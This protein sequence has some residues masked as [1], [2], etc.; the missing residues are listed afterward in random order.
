MMRLLNLRKGSLWNVDDRLASRAYAIKV[1]NIWS[2]LFVLGSAIG[3]IIAVCQSVCL[4]VCH[5][6]YC[7]AHGRCRGWKLYSP[8][9]TALHTS[10]Y[11]FAVGCS[12]RSATT[13]SEN[14]IA[15]ISASVTIVTWPWLFQTRNFRR[16]G[17]AVIPYVVR[18][19]DRLS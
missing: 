10:S 3:M 7:G 11:T 6:V 12:Y 17:S 15:E 2:V 1:R 9:S 8:T 16:F 18:S 5:D 13:H 14:R 19:Y 4:S